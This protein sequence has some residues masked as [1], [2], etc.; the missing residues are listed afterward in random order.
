MRELGV[1]PD[2]FSFPLIIRACTSIVNPKVCKIV[3][4]HATLMGFQFHL[5][6]ANELIGMYGKIGQMDSAY[7]LLNRMP[8]RNVVSW[9]V[10]ISGYAANY[11]C[12][13][14][15]EMFGRMELED[16]LEPN[17]ITWTSLLSAYARCGQDNEVLRLFKEMRGMGIAPNAEAVSVVL[18]VCGDLSAL[19]KGKEIHGYVVRSGFEDYVFV[20]NSLICMYGKHGQR[21]DAKALF[22]EIKIKNLVTWNA[23]IS[24][25]AAAGLCDDAFEVFSQLEKLGAESIIKPNVVS[26]SAVIGGFA[27]N[28]RGN[29]SLELFRQMQH[30]GVDPNSVTIATI[31]SV[32]AEL[33][34]LR[35]GR[36]IH[37]HVIRSLMNKNILVENGLLHMYAKCGCLRDGCSVFEWIED[38]DLISWNSMIAGYG[39]HGFVEDALNTFYKMIEAGFRPDGITF[40]ALLSACSHTG[41][42]TKGRQL[43]DQMIHEYMLSPQME[44]YACMVDLL[45][46]AGLLQEAS[47]FVKMIPI[48]P[49]A[50]VWGAL[51]NSCRIYKNM[52]VAEE[53]FKSSGLHSEGTGSYM[54]LSNIYAECERW[55]DSAKMRVLTK[56]KG[57]KKSPGQSW[58][59]VKKKIYLFSAGNLMQPG[60]EKV[61]K[62]LEDLGLQ[63]EDS[64]YIPDE[65]FALQYVAEEEADIVCAQ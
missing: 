16:G 48:K 64:G 33:A 52:A 46:R 65:T 30:A 59:E 10:I 55:E 21:E 37:G 39:M 42:V 9:N 22:S 11:D 12:R 3:H 62:V 60:L 4:G 5:H 40:V 50:C 2:G 49:N 57:L 36:E 15:F 51:L 17:L 26:W 28:G 47:K 1:A 34:A 27:S 23:L 14:A 35:L 41:L 45:G 20:K 38:R 63:M 31:L 13:G 8:R 61:Y 54:L 18:S 24:S 19:D 29:E 58:I 6:V 43:Y 7:Q 56:M 44:H 25:Y 53:T 32:C